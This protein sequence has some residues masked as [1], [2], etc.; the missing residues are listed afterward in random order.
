MSD[1]ARE[2][3]T[4]GQLRATLAKA[5]KDVLDGNLEIEKADV[6]HKL[7]RNITDSIYSETKIKMFQHDLK[8][9]LE[10]LGA[11]P[12]GDPTDVTEGK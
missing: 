4:T 2:I 9:A 3:K 1:A 12:L 10:P 6:L 11:L 8:E 5:A 7:A